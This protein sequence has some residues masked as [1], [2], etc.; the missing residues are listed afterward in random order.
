MLKTMSAAALSLLLAG[1]GG[2]AFAAGNSQDT[3]STSRASQNATPQRSQANAPGPVGFEEEE[4]QTAPWTVER[5]DKQNHDLV[6]RAPDGTQS[7]VNIPPGTP[8]FD[9]LKKNDKIQLDY[10]EAAVVGLPGNSAK[11]SSQTGA[12]TA[13]AT[14]NNA[15]NKQVRRIRKVNDNNQMQHSGNGHNANSPEHESR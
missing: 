14:A 9:A 2:I 12:G 3:P 8:G 1:G 15:T 11:P 13:G 6:L 7:T 4:V 10:F 5:V